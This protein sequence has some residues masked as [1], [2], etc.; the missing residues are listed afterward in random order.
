M[1]YPL[2]TWVLKVLLNKDFERDIFD[3]RDA[4][5]N[6]ITLEKRE[7]LIKEIEAAHAD[8]DFSWLEIAYDT[9]WFHRS[10]RDHYH[11][12]LIT[13]EEVFEHF[14]LWIWYALYPETQ[15]DEQQLMRMFIAVYY[16]LRDV[17]ITVGGDGWV[18]VDDIMQGLKDRNVY[19]TNLQRFHFE[20]LI[21]VRDDMIEYKRRLTQ[22]DSRVFYRISFITHLRLSQFDYVDSFFK[23]MVAELNLDASEYPELNWPTKDLPWTFT[24]KIDPY[25]DNS[26]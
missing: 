20:Y 10:F 4:V 3:N 6:S 9:D 2:L 1:K 14:K 21:K 19:W 17:A 7:G 18:S 11:L 24:R 16:M 13:E 25:G 26:Y 12:V 23:E 5:Y 15:Y 22:A 8:P